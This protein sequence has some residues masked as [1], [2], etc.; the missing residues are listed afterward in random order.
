MGETPDGGTARTLRWRLALEPPG[1]A[2]LRLIVHARPH[3]PLPPVPRPAGRTRRTQPPRAFDLDRAV[4]QGMTDLDL[5][6]VHATYV[7]SK[8]GPSIR[9]RFTDG[10]APRSATALLV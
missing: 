4:E 8:V 1:R 5:L 10:T 2:E 6:T 9:C 3:A 7:L